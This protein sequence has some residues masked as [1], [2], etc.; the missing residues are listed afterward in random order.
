ML[1]STD[2]KEATGRAAPGRSRRIVA[3][4][5]M[6]PNLVVAYDDM[7]LEEAATLLTENQISGAPVEGPEGRLVGVIS[8]SDIARAASEH[9]QDQADRSQP[10]FFL[11]GWEDSVS[12]DELRGFHVDDPGLLV[13]EMMTPTVYSVDQDAPVSEIAAMMLD[14]HIHRVLVKQGEKVVGIVTTSDLLDL[15]VDREDAGS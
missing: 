13:R 9:A 3:R 7:T 1:M 5:L 15:L 4:D 10:D 14:A 2:P 6:T 12:P 11:H 8:V